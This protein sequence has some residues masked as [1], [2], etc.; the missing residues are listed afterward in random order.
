MNRNS[1]KTLDNKKITELAQDLK[2]TDTSIVVKDGTIL[3]TV[4]NAK[5]SGN[6][7]YGTIEIDGEIIEYFVK[8]G[9]TLS[10]IRRGMFGTSVSQIIPVG[11][12]V[13]DNGIKTNI[14]YVDTEVKKIAYGNGLKQIFDFDFIPKKSNNSL[15]YRDTIPSNY[16][17]CDEIEVYVA[18]QRLVKTPT[19]VYDKNIGQDSYKDTNK[20]IQSDKLVEAEFSVDGVN[21]SVRLTKAPGAGALVVIIARRGTTWQSPTENIPFVYSKSTIA[22]F[23]NTKQVDLPK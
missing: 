20:Q 4:E 21:N 14:P 19:Y 23:V 1:Y 6:R 8:N 5:N 22:S 13:F 15:W 10:Q 16:G 11:T 7:I 3:T 9:N 12:K 2:I 18:G 17:Q